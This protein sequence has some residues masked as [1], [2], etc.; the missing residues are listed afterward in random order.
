MVISLSADSGIEL[1]E[2]V[3]N[4]YR[5]PVFSSL[6]N[7]FIERAS[8]AGYKFL[9]DFVEAHSM[10]WFF[11]LFFGNLSVLIKNLQTLTKLLGRLFLRLLGFKCF[12]LWLFLYC[13]HE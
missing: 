9:L 6:L 1:V 8:Q 7:K 3:G 10:L 13:F 4:A 11:G 2:H 12:G 5:L